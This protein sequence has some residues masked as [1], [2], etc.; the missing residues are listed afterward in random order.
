MQGGAKALGLQGALVH[1][2]VGMGRLKSGSTFWRGAED[3]MSQGLPRGWGVGENMWHLCHSVP[4]SQPGPSRP[5]GLRGLSSARLTNSAGPLGR[6][7]HNHTRICSPWGPGCCLPGAPW[8]WLRPGQLGRRAEYREVGS[9]SH[10]PPH[11][12]Q[13]SAPGWPRSFG[14]WRE[15]PG[16]VLWLPPAQLG[17]ETSWGL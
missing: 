16:G 17:A 2:A 4:A 5:R 8:A 1:W 12:R 14:P 9:R 15:R 7:R 6:P 13:S 3:E 10:G 11:P